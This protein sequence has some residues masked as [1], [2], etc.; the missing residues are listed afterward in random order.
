MACK[1]IGSIMVPLALKDFICDVVVSITFCSVKSV[2]LRSLPQVQSQVIPQTI[3]S[4]IRLSVRLTNLHVFALVLRSV[5]YWSKVSSLC[6]LHVLNMCLCHVTFLCGIQYSSNFSRILSTFF[7]S[8]GL[9][10]VN[11]L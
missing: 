1:S 6:W 4:R 3:R 5:M 10:H 11:L 2:S 8:P 7:S 9:S